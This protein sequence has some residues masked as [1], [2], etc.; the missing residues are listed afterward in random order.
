MGE[1]EH[2]VT[3]NRGLFSLNKKIYFMNLISK[4]QGLLSFIE[5]ILNFE[6]L[7]MPSMCKRTVNPN[8][9]Y[10]YTNSKRDSTILDSLGLSK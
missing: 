5:V 3:K 7:N 6:Y 2:E 1:V 10:F 9:D 4:K 8:C